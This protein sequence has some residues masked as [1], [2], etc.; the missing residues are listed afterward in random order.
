[1]R[2]VKWTDKLIF[3]VNSVLAFLLLLSYTLPYISPSTFPLLSVLSLAVPLLLVINI[4][5]LLYWGARLKK[6]MLLSLL[7]LLLGLSHLKSLYKFGGT[8]ANI[9]NDPLTVM[10]YNVHQFDRFDWIKDNEEVGKDISDFVKEQN[11]MIF[12]AQE[13]YYSPDI[14]F[15]HFKYKYIDFNN[16]TNEVGQAIYSQIP[17]IKKGTFK[18]DQTANNAVFVDV[19]HEKDTLRVYNVHFQSHRINPDAKELQKEATQKLMK[20]IG[21]SFVKQQAQMELVLEH[22]KKSPYRNIV[23]GDFNNTAYSY[24]YEKLREQDLLDAFKESGS[25]FG[26]TYNFRFFPT[27]IDF[28]LADKSFQVDFFKNYDL[29]L[30]DHYPIMTGLEM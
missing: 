14:D 23:A 5:F 29:L 10:S 15:S 18:F 6:Q 21:G 8:T 1:M 9:E 17:I 16:N 13:F 27:R 11:P 3:L 7:I 28:V 20:R 12:C 22:I 26:K 30:S 4:C 24:I 2:Y 19:I 25:G